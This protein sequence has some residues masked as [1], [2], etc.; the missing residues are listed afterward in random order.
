MSMYVRVVTVLCAPMSVDSIVKR[1]QQ[2]I[3]EPFCQEIV[4]D[5]LNYSVDLAESPYYYVDK[6]DVSYQY[7]Y[8][9]IPNVIYQA[10]CLN[11][12]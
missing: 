6:Q 12:P 2:R 10:Y 4:N 3:L 11:R 9:G 1:L 5:W 8:L 7:L